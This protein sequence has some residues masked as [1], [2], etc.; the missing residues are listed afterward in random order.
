MQEKGWHAEL[1]VHLAVRGGIVGHSKA[2]VFSW[3]DMPK[4]AQ[5][6][7]G[8]DFW[9]EINKI[10]PRQGPSIDVYKTAKEVVV[11]IEVPGISTSENVDIKL[12]GLKLAVKGEI[13][14]AY[15]VAR[16]ELLQNERFIGSFKREI[17]LPDDINTQIPI[18]AQF[19]LGLVELR[20]PRLSKA[21]EKEINIIFE[22]EAESE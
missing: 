12:K 21:D 2:K 19:K 11:V 6:Y 1:F 5:Y 22:Q 9:G 3:A 10:I 8:E 14:W 4:E 18:E 17:T 7:L 13:P 15:P 20:I 16:E